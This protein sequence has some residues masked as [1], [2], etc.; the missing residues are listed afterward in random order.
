MPRAAVAGVPTPAEL[1]EGRELEGGWRVV[2]RIFQTDFQTGSFFSV[3]YEVR[4]PDGARG[5]LKALDY[6]G[7]FKNAAI[8]AAEVLNKMT[9]DYLY[10]KQILDLCGE[11]RLA[12]I[13]RAI[14]SGQVDVD[15]SL[16]G[17]GV[18]QYLIFEFASAG[19]LRLQVDPLDEIEAEEVLR[20]L[21]DVSAALQQ[22]H[23]NG[24]SHQD[25]KASNILDFGHR[26]K[27][28]DL[29]RSVSRE[30]IAPHDDLPFAGQRAYAPPEY[31]YEYKRGNKPGD[32][33]ERRFGADLYLLGSIGTYLLTGLTMNALFAVHLPES[34][35]W[36]SWTGDFEDAL[37]YLVSA[38]AEIK[39]SLS[40]IVP[41]EIDELVELIGYLTFP[42]PARRGHP[43]DLAGA[44]NRQALARFISR[45][46]A[47]RARARAKRIRRRL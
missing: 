1:L 4:G 14:G 30:L 19:D 20:I 22:L 40:K 45:F 13:V 28:G 2:R 10:E 11:R 24:I 16:G 44:A 5:F 32:W 36:D 41:P 9:A 34:L 37:P 26:F 29:G 23:F 25:I 42:N 31:N 38:Q 33:N 27:L 12:R 17:L 8:S 35:R 3:G 47:L 46:N 6:V 43:D 18:V 39:V 7:A 21:G 15:P